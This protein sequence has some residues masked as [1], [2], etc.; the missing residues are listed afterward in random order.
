[1]K[2]ANCY[3][4]FA[5]LW[6]PDFAKLVANL[7]L[8]TLPT[9]SPQ[10]HPSMDEERVELRDKAGSVEIPKSEREYNQ[11]FGQW[12]RNTKGQIDR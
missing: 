3:P 11:K 6:S 5:N 9:S 1:M 12:F 10:V 4:E 7:S 8:L 2:F